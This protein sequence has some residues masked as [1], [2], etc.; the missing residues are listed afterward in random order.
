M[1]MM[2]SWCCLTILMWA[3]KT[4]RKELKGDILIM[5]RVL[6]FY[7]ETEWGAYMKSDHLPFPENAIHQDPD[8]R[9]EQSFLRVLLLSLLYLKIRIPREILGFI[10]YSAHWWGRLFYSS[11]SPEHTKPFAFSWNISVIG[12]SSIE[13]YFKIWWGLDM[14][15]GEEINRS[16]DRWKFNQNWTP[17][18]LKGRDAGG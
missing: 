11:S 2:M 14:V 12:S 1:L 9:A 4:F 6:Q 3:E 5:A 17:L 13:Y 18:Q 16:A 10:P 8:T 7:D 15:W